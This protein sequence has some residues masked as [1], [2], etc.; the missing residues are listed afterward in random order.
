MGWT[1]IRLDD[2]LK[3]L[4]LALN[5]PCP[6]CWMSP[7]NLI[8]CNYQY[9]NTALSLAKLERGACQAEARLVSATLSP[10]LEDSLND[11]VMTSR[12]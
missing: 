11:D 12:I 4:A 6:F 1:A 7:S 2:I 3:V 8:A 10:D 9:D 5:L